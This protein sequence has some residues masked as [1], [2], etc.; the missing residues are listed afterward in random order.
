[1]IDVQAGSI[2]EG[3]AVLAGI[4]ITLKHIQS[5]ELY[6]LFREAIEEAKDNDSRDPD[7][8]GDGL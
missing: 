7:P 1:M 2:E 4:L 3:S 5:S 6:L 8:Q